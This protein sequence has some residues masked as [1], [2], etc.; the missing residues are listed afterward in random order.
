[1]RTLFALTV[2]LAVGV[3]LVVVGVLV[4]EFGLGQPIIC[5]GGRPGQTE[6]GNLPLVVSV[7][8]IL[9]GLVTVIG[10]IIYAVRVW[11]GSDS[12]YPSD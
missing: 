1:M 2:G 4:F 5:H 6:C 11:E 8:V 7:F 12:G 3:S 10:A 9:A